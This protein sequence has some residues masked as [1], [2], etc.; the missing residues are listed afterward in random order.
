[1]RFVHLRTHYSNI[2]CVQLVIENGNY[3]VQ[4]VQKCGDNLRAAFDRANTVCTEVTVVRLKFLCSTSI[5]L[6]AVATYTASSPQLHP[7]TDHHTH[8]PTHP[9]THLH[10][11][12]MRTHTHTHTHTHTCTHT[13]TQESLYR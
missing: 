7:H 9:P 1:M 2:N 4:H 5:W 3:F 13:H 11:T 12:Q 6:F 10:H 8:T